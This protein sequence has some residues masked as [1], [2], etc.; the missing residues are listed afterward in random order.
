M[1]AKILIVVV[2]LMIM[3]ACSKDTYSSTPKLT[4]KSVNGQEFPVG[5]TLQF[6]FEVTDKEGDIQD[7]MWLEKNSFAC[8]A[9]GYLLSPNTVPN[10]TSSKDLKAELD[11]NV[12]YGTDF[13]GCTNRDD[14]CYFRFWIKDK[15]GHVSDTVQSPTIK[16][17]KG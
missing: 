13:G 12:T 1:K 11:I 10:F 6:K 2:C 17:L 15:A 5:S 14:S 9:D 4:F 3:A 8:G 16:L 7:T